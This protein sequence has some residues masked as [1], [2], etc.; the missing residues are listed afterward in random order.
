MS[1]AAY[2][3]RGKKHRDLA[4]FLYKKPRRIPRRGLGYSALGLFN[5]LLLSNRIHLRLGHRDYFK[6]AVFGV[7]GEY[8]GSVIKV[9]IA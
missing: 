1:I 9:Y 5:L 2:N 3:F 7:K 6:L 8:E 4:C